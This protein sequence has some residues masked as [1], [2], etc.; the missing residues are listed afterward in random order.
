MKKNLIAASLFIISFT[1]VQAQ[2]TITVQSNGDATFY[3]DWAS[4]W[5]ATQVGDTIYL[6]G[7]TFNI[8]NLVINRKVT[9]IGVG[10]DPTQTHDGLFS[11]LNGN[12]Y[13]VEGSDESLLHGFQ[14]TN[15]Y[16][17]TTSWVNQAV[18]NVTISRCRITNLT[19]LGYTKPSLAQ[20]ILFKENVLGGAIYG[21]DAQQ[22]Q[23]VK[24]I[25]DERVYEFDGYTVFT[26]N[27]FTYYYT[28]TVAWAPLQQMKN[29]LFQNN[30]FRTT[31]YPLNTGNCDN[32]L[33]Q[34]NIFAANITINT[35]TDLNTWVGNFFNQPLAEVFVNFT[36]GAFNPEHDYHLLPTSV[37][38]GAGTDGFDIGI[39]GTAVPYKEGAVPFNPQITFEQVSGQTDEAGNIEVQ[40]N[41]SAQER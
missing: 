24:N 37:G 12:I 16:F 32:N 27:I 11:H 5:E 10:H 23:F 35:Q 15:L 17:N 13:F 38:V 28:S 41:V 39:Y 25:I 8:G 26:N 3:T 20:H 33:L 21:R 40:V 1:W 9:I 30:I 7:G 31:S 6:P 29:A 18:S 22:I 14:F 19:Q 4:A 2:K 36:G 34:A